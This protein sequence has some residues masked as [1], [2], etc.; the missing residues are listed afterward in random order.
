M[1]MASS[2]LS[3]IDIS[4]VVQP[5]EMRRIRFEP[6]LQLGLLQSAILR[7]DGL[8]A[9]AAAN[10]VVLLDPLKLT[11]PNPQMGTLHPAIRGILRGTGTGNFSASESSSG[12][13]AIAL[14]GRNQLIQP[15]PEFRFVFFPTATGVV[16]DPGA[17]KGD[18][19]ARDALLKRLQVVNNVR[20]ARLRGGGGAVP[21][22]D[23]P[24]P[25]AHYHVLVR[26][27]GGAGNSIPL[28]LE[29]LA[30][31][32]YP[33]ANKGLGFPPVRAADPATLGTIRQTTQANIDAP[34]PTLKAFRLSDDPKEEE[35]NLYLSEPI[36]M[37]R[38]RITIPE[39]MTL[40]GSFGMPRAILWSEDRLRVSIDTSGA[41][42]AIVGLFASETDGA[43]R[44]LRPRASG[45]A[46][47]LPGGYILGPN[48]PPMGGEFPAL[49]TFGLVDGGSG[50]F[51]HTTVDM[52]LPSRR[53]P[54]H[55]ERTINNQD[56]C[57]SA[58]GSGWD[59]YYNQRLIELR[60]EQIPARQHVA[61][62]HAFE[63]D[64]ERHRRVERCGI[65][66]WPGPH[67]YFKKQASTPPAFNDDPLVST[68]GWPLDDG[69]CY[70]PHEN[71][72]GVFDLLFRFP[73][74][75][76]VRLTTDGMQFWYA[77]NGRL[78]RIYHRFP[79]N[80]Q[81]LEYNGAA[82]CGRSSI[83]PS[84]RIVFLR[85]AIIAAAAPRISSV[86][87]RDDER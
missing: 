5:V 68:L 13:R 46:F 1:P 75:E 12:L 17:L 67:D 55:F 29:S 53:M 85:S 32:G 16:K 7:P 66:R 54:I 72:K 24:S 44:L 6:E 52:E 78:T 23:P 57:H 65:P 80:Y 8:I 69:T 42:Q 86:A 64:A 35:F 58:F 60:P 82:S 37:L 59:F 49:G 50:E 10:D 51:R 27:H 47:T 45:V 76:F 87:R 41:S 70:L 28:A 84:R 39:L 9:L 34:I 38:E 21:S 15:P 18:H 25:A 61:D 4:N 20:P 81:V 43:E 77:K 83:A 14:G 31:S 36:V 11:E 26:A 40:N 74:G 48:P 56:T 33:V 71:E 2:K 73:S 79:A 30:E 19:D 22:V 3:I 63:H 62:H